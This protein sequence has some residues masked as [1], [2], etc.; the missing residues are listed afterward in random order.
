MSSIYLS[1]LKNSF[2]LLPAVLAFVAAAALLAACPPN[3]GSAESDRFIAVTYH[4]ITDKPVAPDD[5]TPQKFIEQL[6]FFKASGFHPVS[7]SDILEAAA[8][9]K[10]LPEKALLLTFDDGYESFYKIVYPALKLFNY[11]AVLSIVTSWTDRRDSPGAFY[12]DKQF[13]SWDQVREVAASGLVTMAAHSDGLHNLVDSNPQG[14]IEPA[15]VTFVYDRKSSSYE[16]E[17]GFRRRIRADMEKTLAVF[18]EKLGKKPIVYT[19]PYGAYNMI[20][21]D[22]GKKTG[23]AAFLTLDDGFGDIHRLD[24]VNRYYAHNM[25]Y[26]V[27]TFKEEMKQGL[28][29]TILIRAVRIDLDEIVERDS[30]EKSDTNLGKCLDRLSALGVNTV[31]VPAF[32]DPDG[33]GSARALYFGNAV[34][35]VEMDFLG[36]AVNRIRAR[37][38]QVFVSMPALAFELPDASKAEAL[39]VRERGAG[40]TV[41]VS[42]ASYKR[43]SPFDA[44]N[45]PVSRSMFRDLAAQMEFDGILIEDDAYL[46]NEEDYHP[47][48]S[49]AYEKEFGRALS[50]DAPADPESEKKWTAM[51]TAALD[52]YVAALIDTVRVF[53]PTVKTARSIYSE[54]VTDPASQG[55]FAQEL[56]SFI[57]DYDFTVIR[58][59]SRMEKIG[60]KSSVKKWMRAMFDRVKKENGAA[61]AIFEVQAYDWD[62][63]AWIDEATLKEEVS[64]LLSL[65]VK[66]VAYYPDGVTV[67]KPRRDAIASVVSGQEFMRD[68][69]KH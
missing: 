3:A 11:P 18:E 52:A 65:G 14:N 59:H 1:G 64:Y 47:A 23:F 66:H 67:D 2:R 35:P 13:M 54:A 43:L 6:G 45:L 33:T 12:K 50:P 28:L 68:V 10:V 31:I 26:W 4:D 60:G 25:L 69:F 51:K 48:A 62:K 56:A 41:R 57:K 38:M 27:P 44:R 8:G 53:R 32:S 55:K 49:S 58:V 34:L 63:Q 61:K 40:G 9:K 20:A 39:W 36:H 17:D 5:F 22:E 24:R 19:W 42:D 16:T 37:G 46:S 30:Y 21:L 29:D 7:M 15:A